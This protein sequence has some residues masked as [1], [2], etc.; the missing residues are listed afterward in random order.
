MRVAHRPGPSLC[1]LA[2]RSRILA[3]HRHRQLI[4]KGRADMSA[5]RKLSRRLVPRAVGEEA[6]HRNEQAIALGSAELPPAE[7]ERIQRLQARRE[8]LTSDEMAEARRV[9]HAQLDT[10]QGRF[11]TGRKKPY[12]AMVPAAAAACVVRRVAS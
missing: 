9:Q 11:P 8:Q 10:L 4:A 6:R 5:D 12:P 7:L 3:P 1:R 2:G